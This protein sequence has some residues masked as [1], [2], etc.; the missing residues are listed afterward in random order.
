MTA[1]TDALAAATQ[2]ENAAIFTY[3]VT[4]AFVSATRRTTVADYTAAHRAARDAL[5]AAILAGGATPPDMAS[6]YTL[7]VQVT[8]P[9]SAARAALA[10]ENDC[11]TAYRSALERADS[12]SARR[13]AVDQLTDCAQR[14]ATWRAALGERPVTV[15]FPGQPR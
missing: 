2:A 3:G 12:E 10:A 9:T 13:L 15:A 1:T 4:T 7:P 6:G 8:D 14:A 5:N 11:A